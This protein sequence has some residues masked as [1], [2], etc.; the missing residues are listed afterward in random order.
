[1]ERRRIVYSGRVQGVGFRATAVD[2]ATGHPVSGWVRNEADGTVLM[3]IQGDAVTIDRCLKALST[4][5]GWFIREEKTRV[6][7][8]EESESGFTVRR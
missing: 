4:R 7:P 8:V 2:V 1:M 3:E 6:I 5:M